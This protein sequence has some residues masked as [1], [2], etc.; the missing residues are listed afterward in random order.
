MNVDDPPLAV[1]LELY[2]RSPQF[3]LRWLRVSDMPLHLCDLGAFEGVV[4]GLPEPCVADMRV[5]GLL[6]EA[7]VLDGGMRTI[8]R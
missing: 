1:H 5:D 3:E 4:D 8:S 7:V 6:L 2:L